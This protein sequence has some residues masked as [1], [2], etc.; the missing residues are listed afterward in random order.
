MN[1]NFNDL[2]NVGLNKS[3]LVAIGVVLAFI[4]TIL[5]Y[6]LVFPKR[7][8][9][10]QP[11]FFQFLKNFFEVR[12]LLIEKII[13]FF[14]VFLTFVLIFTGIIMMFIV[15]PFWYGLVVTILG[16]IVLR[17]VHELLMLAILLV[18]NTIEI[19]NK[20]PYPPKKSRKQSAPANTFA[21]APAPVF[22]PNGVQQPYF[23][24]APAPSF[25]P[26]VPRVCPHCGAP[27]GAD[28]D[29]CA[30]CGSRIL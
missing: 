25:D 3:W 22:D 23:E 10:N 24:P 29:F 17:F 19:N 1:I 8:D 15:K 27:A 9:G 12:Y 20:L 7:K 30:E 21:G 4:V 2:A 18:K 5:L 28:S 6:I 11:G 16:P 14:Y 13:K 26:S